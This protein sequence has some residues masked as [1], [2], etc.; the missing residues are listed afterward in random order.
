VIT[1]RKAAELAGW[2]GTMA[3]VSA[4]ALVSFNLLSSESWL[5]QIINLTGAIGIII[6]SSLKK[7]RQTMILNIFWALI[8]ITAL[9]RLTVK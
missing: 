2:Y 1:R 8:A 6:I 5:F 4:Y 7:V 9:I 3:I